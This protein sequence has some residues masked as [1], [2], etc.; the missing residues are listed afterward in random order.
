MLPPCGGPGSF[1]ETGLH[2]E[3][4]MAAILSGR[5]HSGFGS[6]WGYLLILAHESLSVTVRLKTRCPGVESVSGQK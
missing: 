2:K 1:P 6:R 5:R 3:Y 4:E